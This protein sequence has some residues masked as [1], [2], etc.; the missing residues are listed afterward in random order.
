M[1]QS[2]VNHEIF[3]SLINSWRYLPKLHSCKAITAKYKQ[4]KLQILWGFIRFPNFVK[5]FK[6]ICCLESHNNIRIDADII[7]CSFQRF[8]WVHLLLSLIK[9]PLR[10]EEYFLEPNWFNSQQKYWLERLRD[11]YTCRKRGELNNQM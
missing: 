4:L 1:S 2:P 6:C 7:F 3:S 9:D 8:H 11:M 10:A 5:R